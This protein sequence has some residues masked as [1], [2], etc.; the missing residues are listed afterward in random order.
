MRT[1]K[2][3]SILKYLIV[4]FVLLFFAGTTG[5][6]YAQDEIVIHSYLMRG[7]REGLKAGPDP[8]A[9]S[10]TKPITLNICPE[11]RKP[12]E[13]SFE[14]LRNEVSS[15]YQVP[16][17]IGLT[18]A[19]MVWDG[20]RENLNQAVMANYYYLYPI[21][22]YP[23][24]VNQNTLSLRVEAYKYRPNEIHYHYKPLVRLKREIIYGDFRLFVETQKI[25]DGVGGEKWLDTELTLPF[26]ESVIL[27][28]PTCDHSYF[29]AF[30]AF[31]R[32]ARQFTAG[33]ASNK[34]DFFNVSDADPVCGKIVGRGDGIE[35]KNRAEASLVYKGYT[36]LFCSQ[37]CMERFQED[38]DKYLRKSRIKYFKKKINNPG[39]GSLKRKFI[40]VQ[41]SSPSDEESIP[42]RPLV[43]VRPVF[44]EACQKKGIQGVVNAELEVDKAGN[45]SE[46]RIPKTLHPE[47]DAAAEAA[48]RQWKYEPS[49]KDGKPIAAEYK[50]DVDFELKEKEL[51]NEPQASIHSP[52]EMD[53]ILKK[54]A[55][56]CKRLEDA[57]LYFICQEKITETIFSSRKFPRYIIMKR[58]LPK[59]R[60][61]TSP[62]PIF[63][64]SKFNNREKNS[65]VYDYQ[66][67]RKQGRVMERRILEL[68]N[69]NPKHEAYVPLKTKRFY[70]YK[71]VYGPIGLL[72]QDSQTLYN[73]SILGEESVDGREAW[74]IEVR[75]KKLIPGKPNYGK[76]WV[77]KEES[78]VLK[79][80][81]EAESL[82]GYEMIWADYVT[83][84][85]TPRINMELYFGLEKDGLLYPTKI[86]CK[87]AF[88]DPGED[89]SKV[90]EMKV[91]YNKYEFFSVKTEV[92]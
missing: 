35:E 74:V 8:A 18:S 67:I 63:G 4:L 49:I 47:L 12:G 55:Y 62:D 3:I 27:I 71:P 29:L 6:G 2:R 84:D 34:L 1:K 60:E 24:S 31:K 61:K 42:F 90:Y 28:L 56:Y 91:T 73:Y 86:I 69:G 68:E 7:F 17:V 65:Y 45:V 75:P 51:P 50:V 40:E 43:L 66:L 15:I 26:N 92:K 39:R 5:S 87:E 80:E 52:S 58:H 89:L 13:D 81:I 32:D 33:L 77:D 85:S 79:I 83:R 9:S 46:V 57:A 54:L 53:S 14:F 37:G 78:S 72:S 88:S 44:P 41:K 25:E 76:V 10:F 64:I 20:K 38:P 19:A 23:L 11:S 22:F 82:G 70:M 59:D 30:Q 48:L 21:Q 16:Y 36:F